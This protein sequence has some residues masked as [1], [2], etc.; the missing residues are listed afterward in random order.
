M[1]VGIAASLGLVMKGINTTEEI[2]LL[3]IKINM[4][5][6]QHLND[7]KISYFAFMPL[8]PC[9]VR[10]IEFMPKGYNIHHRDDL[11]F[12]ENMSRIGG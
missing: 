12:L 7:D 11:S 8:T 4:V 6:I 5:P 1:V 3:P 10:F 9:N 2:G